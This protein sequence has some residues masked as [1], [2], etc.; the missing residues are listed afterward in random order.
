MFTSIPFL[1][2]LVSIGTKVITTN[3]TF[4]LLIYMVHPMNFGA[5][6]ALCGIKSILMTHL[7]QKWYSKATE[8]KFMN[9]R[10]YPNIWRHTI[11]AIYMVL[12]WFFC[13]FRPKMAKMY[14]WR[15]GHIFYN[16]CNALP[17]RERILGPKL[18]FS[19]PKKQIWRAKYAWNIKIRPL[20]L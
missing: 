16:F 20:A 9:I 8:N 12:L 13:D 5:F 17:A 10:H 4:I 19:G 6:L 14:N 2:S 1:T 18:I 3:I 11:C 7:C 15:S